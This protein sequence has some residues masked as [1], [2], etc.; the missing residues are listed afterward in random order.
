M[1]RFGFSARASHW[2]KPYQT[3]GRRPVRHKATAARSRL[4]P[5]ARC[6][7]RAAPGRLTRGT[8]R[9]VLP[10]K[11]R[12]AKR[13]L[14]PRPRL[15]IC[16]ESVSALDVSVQA[17]ILALLTTLR[18]DL[19]I[20]LLFISHDLAV[21]R[22]LADSVTVLW[23]GRVIESGPCEQVLTEP[24]HEYTLMLVAAAHRENTSVGTG[25]RED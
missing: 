9:R 23:D 16:D 3:T 20:S 11:A 8:L 25:E 13:P 14:A 7:L 2:L 18:D 4:R 22:L 12:R 5:R 24:R 17:Q 6:S 15:L 21:V 19:G 10:P 1:L